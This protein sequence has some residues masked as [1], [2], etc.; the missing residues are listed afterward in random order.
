MSKNKSDE[1][2]DVLKPDNISRKRINERAI[3]R[4]ENEGGA[5]CYPLKGRT[6][7][8]PPPGRKKKPKILVSCDKSALG[9]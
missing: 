2:T 7:K 3:S 4:W 5:I 1:P 8:M 9:K 6:G